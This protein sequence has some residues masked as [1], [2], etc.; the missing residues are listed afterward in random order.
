MKNEKYA[1][2]DLLKIKRISL[3]AGE[4]FETNNWTWCKEREYYV[5]NVYQIQETFLMLAK[6]AIDAIEDSFGWCATGRL[7]VEAYEYENG[8]IELEYLLELD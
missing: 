5:P 4:M 6:D 8:E 3:M 7:K 2:I 1:V